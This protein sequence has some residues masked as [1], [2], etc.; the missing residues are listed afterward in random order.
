LE[1]EPPELV[2]ETV[3][4]AWLLPE[5]RVVDAPPV[6]LDDF[7]LQPTTAE[8]PKPATTTSANNFFTI[9]PSFP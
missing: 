5:D 6:T 1:P 4:E 7:E 2:D 8:R 3:V 9:I